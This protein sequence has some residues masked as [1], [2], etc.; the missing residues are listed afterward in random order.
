LVEGAGTG[1][2]I[3]KRDNGFVGSACSS[4]VFLDANPVA[5]VAPS[6]KIVLHL[7]EG[8]YLVGAEPNGLCAG[9]LRETRVAV[10][11]GKIVTYRIG[12]GDNGD[13]FILPTAF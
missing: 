6:E 7:P 10:R 2:L 5:D 13:F 12:Y 4:R 8:E 3:V 1:T 11:G 9:G